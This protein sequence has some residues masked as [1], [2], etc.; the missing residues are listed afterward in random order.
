MPVLEAPP[1]S[2]HSHK[3]IKD[4]STTGPTSKNASRSSKKT[5]AQAQDPARVEQT[6]DSPELGGEGEEDGDEDEDDS[7]EE[8][9]SS[10]LPRDK[11]KGRATTLPG[12]EDEE[13]VDQLAEDTV[14]DE[15]DYDD[16]PPT[17]LTARARRS[18]AKTYS[19]RGQKPSP[20]KGLEK[21]RGVPARRGR[22]RPRKEESAPAPKKRGRPRKQKKV[23]SSEEDTDEEEEDELEEATPPPAGQ[24]QRHPSSVPD[25]PRKHLSRKAAEESAKKVHEQLKAPK[26][27]PEAESGE[28][29]EKQN[30]EDVELEG[31]DGEDEAGDQAVVKEPAP[32]KALKGRKGRKGGPPAAVSKSRSSQ[33][34]S[35]TTKKMVVRPL[36][37]RA[38]EE[39]QGEAHDNRLFSGLPADS[40]RQKHKKGKEKR[41]ETLAAAFEPSADERDDVE[42]ED[43]ISVT[44]EDGEEPDPLRPPKLFMHL[45]YAQ[46]AWLP[47]RIWLHD[48]GDAWQKEAMIS[49]ASKETWLKRIEKH[50][51]KLCEHPDQNVTAI[52]P[53]HDAQGYADIYKYA[54]DCFATCITIAWLRD[55]W[56]SSSQRREVVRHDPSDYAARAPDFDRPHDRRYRR[57]KSRIDWWLAPR[58]L[59]R[60]AELY[61]RWK[62]PEENGV[63]WRWVI[64]TMQKEFFDSTRRTTCSGFQDLF[65]VF[66]DD[67]EAEAARIHK[68]ATNRQERVTVEDDER[69]RPNETA[70]AQQKSPERWVE[71]MLEPDM[72][73]GAALSG[74]R[75]RRKPE[76]AA[77]GLTQAATKKWKNA[78]FNIND[79]NFDVDDTQLA[80]RLSN[81][82]NHRPPSHPSASTSSS[83]QSEIPAPCS[84][85]HAASPLQS[86]FRSPSPRQ[87]QSA[88]SS[89][90]PAKP[91]TLDN[92]LKTDLPTALSLLSSHFSLPLLLIR[93]INLACSF[94]LP[95]THRILLALQEM[96]ALTE[97]FADDTTPAAG[98]D[99][100]EAIKTREKEINAELKKL[101]LEIKGLVWS[102]KMDEKLL[103]EGE[104]GEKHV[105]QKFKKSEE[106]VRLRKEQVLEALGWEVVQRE[107]WFPEKKVINAIL[108]GEVDME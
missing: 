3:P 97:R 73:V 25:S 105:M 50:G 101:H 80:D 75:K 24:Q 38:D 12:Q 84:P 64:G 28:D 44:S 106:D 9:S 87:P 39:Q 85:L 54:R 55:V 56:N 51:G 71:R 91:L 49:G 21:E 68:R 72:R 88:A 1:P 93:R 63:D 27:T 94:S 8:V 7:E 65:K 83:S 42:D 20:P 74:P 22:G 32:E 40:Q 66:R 16:L 79:S 46:D 26:Q 43:C 77:A 36:R 95:S 69:A 108:K 61:A 78:L 17:S 18:S 100:E 48:D 52:L 13:E 15:T 82:D 30:G 23:N 11:G 104:E 90:S 76:E 53:E 98:T 34:P 41:Q 62:D 19:K 107:R 4:R 33:K 99:E 89:P 35:A 47:D 45:N 10:L 57:F 67:I 29:Q 60:F 2:H 86:P 14:G 31:E 5:R 103:R 96:A 58:E 102:E 92:L 81:N 37:S 59:R 6:E 70:Q